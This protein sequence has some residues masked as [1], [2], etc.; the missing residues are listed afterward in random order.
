[1]VTTVTEVPMEFVT[2]VETCVD[3]N[4]CFTLYSASRHHRCISPSTG[5]GSH[6]WGRSRP[7][8]SHT[9]LAKKILC[10]SIEPIAHHPKTPRLT[11]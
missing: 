6:E 2:W 9:H 3:I 10:Y 5:E 7:N 4:N 8:G 1:V 11:Y